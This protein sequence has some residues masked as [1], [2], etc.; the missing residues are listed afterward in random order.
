MGKKIPTT[1]SFNLPNG[2]PVVIETGK[3]ATQAD[4]SVVVRIGNTMLFASVVSAKEPREGQSFFPL[5]VDYQ[6]K[7]AGAGRIPGNFFRRESKLSDYE[8]LISRLVD[9]AIRPLFPDGYMN[10]TQVILNLLSG[11]EETLPDAYAALAASAA[12]TLS[13]IP[14]KGP[15]SEV[16]VARIDGNFH[17]NPDKSELE[18]ADLDLIVAADLNNIMMVEGEAN[19]CQEKD[20]VDAIKV[21]HDAIKVQCQAQLDLRAAL[22]DAA[23]AKR[24]VEEPEQDEEIEKKVE[25]LAK[26][27]IYQVAK[28]FLAK[29]ERKDAFEKIAEEVIEYFT[30]EKGEEYIEEKEGLIKDY[31]KD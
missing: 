20:L 30:N 7:F 5:S 1:V 4:G 27:K 9:R 14:W 8:V 31:L 25:Q 23:K 21:A 29:H 10:D 17:I 19:E 16:R 13:D 28:S 11:E 18:R 26:D 24:E 3:L 15:I 6:E 12:L 2:T 22:G